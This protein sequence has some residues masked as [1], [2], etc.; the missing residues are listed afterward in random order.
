[1]GNARGNTFSRYKTLNYFNLSQK[2]SE[3][4]LFFFLTRNHTRLDPDGDEFWQFEWH[5]IGV[6]D[7]PAMIDFILAKTKQSQLNCVGHSQGGTVLAVLLSERPEYSKKISIA[8][9]LA[10]AIILKHYNPVFQ[11]A[12]DNL[13]QIKVSSSRWSSLF[14][15]F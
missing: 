8:H 14:W 12:L 3:F 10:P 5:D 7:L 9:L 2:Y 15:R 11:P 1:M 6:Y 13:Y 4:A